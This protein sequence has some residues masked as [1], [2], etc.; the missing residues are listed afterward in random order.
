M[1]VNSTVAFVGGKA[2]PNRDS[3]TLTNSRSV[4]TDPERF[5]AASFARSSLRSVRKK[6]STT[7]LKRPV[8]RPLVN[9]ITLMTGGVGVGGQLN[10]KGQEPI[11]PK[12]RRAMRPKCQHP[13]RGKGPKCRGLSGPRA[14]LGACVHRAKWPQGPMVQGFSGPES[15]WPIGPLG[16]ETKRDNG[17]KSR[18]PRGGLG[19]VGV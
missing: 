4:Q 17:P 15:Q 9:A 6:I 19:G 11:G 3:T 2:Q 7:S 18:G 10:P 16:P 13:R 8:I 1:F 14:R 5:V 12:V